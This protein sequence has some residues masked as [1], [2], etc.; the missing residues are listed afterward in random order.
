MYWHLCPLYGNEGIVTTCRYTFVDVNCTEM[1]LWCH[2]EMVTSQWTPRCQNEAIVMAMPWVRD[3]IIVTWL[4]FPISCSVYLR[5][6]ANST[7]PKPPSLSVLSALFLSL[8][9]LSIKA[10]WLHAMLIKNTTNIPRC[11]NLI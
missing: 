5:L 11:T 10:S 2:S 9:H 1:P 4:N 3:G 8:L 7:S 6:L